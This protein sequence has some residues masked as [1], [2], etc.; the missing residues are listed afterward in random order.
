MSNIRRCLR[1]AKYVEKVSEYSE[2]F[3]WYMHHTIDRFYMNR[4]GEVR[5]LKTD[6]KFNQCSIRRVLCLIRSHV[7]KHLEYS[8]P[9]RIS[10]AFENVVLCTVNPVVNLYCIPLRDV[11]ILKIIIIG[12]INYF[13]TN[14]FAA[15]LKIREQIKSKLHCGKLSSSTE[16]NKSFSKR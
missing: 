3:S 7:S 8:C 16:N 12:L 11:H 14:L 1:F 9:K 5:K 2:Q 10:S 15:F 4:H 6:L 13:E